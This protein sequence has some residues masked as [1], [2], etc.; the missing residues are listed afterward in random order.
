MILQVCQYLV[1]RLFIQEPNTLSQ[2]MIFLFGLALK[3]MWLEIRL[4]VKQKTFAFSMKLFL[5]I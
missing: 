4:K 5:E 2:L 1:K 3:L